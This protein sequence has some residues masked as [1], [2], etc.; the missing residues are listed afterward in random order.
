VSTCFS[1]NR[2]RSPILLGLLLTILSGVILAACRSGPA[3]GCP[4]AT[5]A[6]LIVYAVDEQS[7]PLVDVKLTYRLGRDDWQLVY[8]TD[9]ETAVGTL[10]GVY[11]I[12]AEKDGYLVVEESIAVP[13]QESRF[14]GRGCGVI[15]QT[16]R[17]ELARVCTVPEQTL[18][19]PVTFTGPPLVTAAGQPWPKSSLALSYYLPGREEP[20]ATC[21]PSRG[22]TFTCAIEVG[23]NPLP[24]F[25]TLRS[26]QPGYPFVELTR[27]IM[28]NAN[29]CLVVAEPA[30]FTAV[31]ACAEP[32]RSLKLQVAGDGPLENIRLYALNDAGNRQE[33]S[34]GEWHDGRC[35]NYRLDLDR[36]GDY[37]LS[38]EQLSAQARLQ[39]EDGIV[40]YAYDSY[41]VHL[42]QGQRRQTFNSAGA[43][44][45]K[46]AFAVS[47]DEGGC[48]W[49]NFNALTFS[50]SDFAPF[51]DPAVSAEAESRLIGGITMTGV[52]DELCRPQP[53]IT[54]VP[55]RVA[56][57]PGTR[58]DDVD[59]SYRVGSTAV[60]WQTGDCRLEEETYLCTAFLP[61][62]TGGLPF[63]VKAVVGGV[64]YIALQIPASS[65]IC[66][67]F[68]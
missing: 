54:P 55:F 5:D 40:S 51:A 52:A 21:R 43:A 19:L 31:E 32:Y 15:T 61:N 42:D 64:D 30:H 22:T 1:A 53:V 57:P 67:V 2:H 45:L 38:L 39:V 36:F 56:L 10:P 63:S 60:P 49:I 18:Q 68:R 11:Q 59:F 4:P 41:T 58:L 44:S 65:N 47:A 24:T 8:I 3:T 35:Q 12:R 48:P 50:R 66:V 16:A 7:S 26:S 62:P 34:C 14:G 25:V 27:T 17:L 28:R 29:G 23:A 33:I 46:A 37:Q 9:G 20:N 13:A 6:A